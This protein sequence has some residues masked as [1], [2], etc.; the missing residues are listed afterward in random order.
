MQN[1]DRTYH[2]LGIPLRTG[3]V[4]PGSENDAKPYRDVHL[5]ERLEEAGCKVIM[6]LPSLSLADVRCRLPISLT[7]MV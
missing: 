6:G 5:R 2:I 4:Y 1:N 3:S 7:M